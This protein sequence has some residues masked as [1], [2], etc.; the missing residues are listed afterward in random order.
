MGQR[1]VKAWAYNDGFLA[2]A[3]QHQETGYR[4]AGRP[5]QHVPGLGEEAVVYETVGIGD[6][7]KRLLHRTPSIGG[8]NVRP[9]LVSSARRDDNSARRDDNAG[10]RRKPRHDGR[11]KLIAA[12]ESTFAQTIAGMTR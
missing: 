12:A 2:V 1:L 4:E 10:W 6:Q 9:V 8:G 7:A 5:R 3:G 11:D